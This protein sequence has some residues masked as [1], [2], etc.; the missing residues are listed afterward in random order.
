MAFIQTN[1]S[2]AY[3]K[4][5]NN[6][7]NVLKFLQKLD[8]NL[9]DKKD[10][11]RLYPILVKFDLKENNELLPVLLRKFRVGKEIAWRMLDD[12]FHNNE[13]KKTV[14]PGVEAI[15]SYFTELVDKECDFPDNQLGDQFFEQIS[16]NAKRAIILFGGK[17]N[18][19][20]D[21][22]N[23]EILKNILEP[24]INIPRV[25]NMKIDSFEL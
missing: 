19:Y 6:D 8:P 4:L 22:E 12:A 13:A 11:E 15:V 7:P 16:P 1:H 2:K 14:L 10:R 21:I 20:I 23:D 18:K 24:P 9:A 17:T 25:K 5:V 3:D